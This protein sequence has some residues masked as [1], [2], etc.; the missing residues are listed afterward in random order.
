MET[1]TKLKELFVK[2]AKEVIP[3]INEVIITTK[4]TNSS[5]YI[6]VGIDCN[7][8]VLYVYKDGGLFDWHFFGSTYAQEMKNLINCY[9]IVHGHEPSIQMI[10]EFRC[11]CK[12]LKD[13]TEFL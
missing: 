12:A 10:N 5:N 1:K 9:T 8:P 6:E 11:W 7:R 4:N 2:C 13:K 3:T